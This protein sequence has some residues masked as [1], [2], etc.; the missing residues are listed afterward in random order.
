MTEPERYD[1]GAI[2][3]RIAVFENRFSELSARYAEFASVLN[4]LSERIDEHLESGEEM[5]EIARTEQENYADKKGLSG[6]FAKRNQGRINAKLVG[7]IERDFAVMRDI[8]ELTARNL[9]L[10][11]DTGE[12]VKRDV[13]EMMESVVGTIQNFHQATSTSLR[14][15]GDDIELLKQLA[16]KALLNHPGVESGADADETNPIAGDGKQK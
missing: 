7:A 3:E 2:E 16:S 11:N 9:Q 15:M 4:Q 14:F 13:K 1:T 6:L 5:L 10:V 12:A 8:Q